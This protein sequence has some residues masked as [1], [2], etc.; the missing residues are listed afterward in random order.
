[1]ASMGDMWGNDSSKMTGRPV[2]GDLESLTTSVSED[3]K[4][5]VWVYDTLFLSW[6]H[7]CTKVF[8]FV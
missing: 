3:L 6:V 2:P 8:L 7:T 1:M 5:V 4:G